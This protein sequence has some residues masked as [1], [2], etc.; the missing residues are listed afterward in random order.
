MNSI[1]TLGGVFGILIGGLVIGVVI[2]VGLLPIV[3]INRPREL[4]EPDEDPRRPSKDR[5]SAHV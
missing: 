4:T 5:M 3:F 2:A 1:T